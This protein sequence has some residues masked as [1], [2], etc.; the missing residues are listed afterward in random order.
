[1]RYIVSFLFVLFSS[2]VAAQEV[3][4]PPAMANLSKQRLIDEFIE[5]SYYKESLINYAKDYLELKM[6]DYNVDPPKQKLTKEQI[7]TIVKNFNFDDFKI[8]LY[9]SFSLI[10]EENLKA[11]IRL[12]KSIGNQLSRNN[13]ALLM[14]SA[15]D[16][17]IKN[18]MDYAIE[19]IK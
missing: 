2:F 19:N 11:L 9:S 17:N 10:S 7:H 8:S 18:Q 6:F 5:V 1:M 14:T 3:P 4:S 13:S 16:L 15:I 12:H